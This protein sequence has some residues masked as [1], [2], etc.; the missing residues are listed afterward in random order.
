MAFV[1]PVEVELGSTVDV[2][3]TSIADVEVTLGV[4]LNSMPVVVYKE[5]G[6]GLGRIKED[7]DIF[8]LGVVDRLTGVDVYWGL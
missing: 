8:E 7:N 1:T 4:N 5:L 6:V 3:K 2:R